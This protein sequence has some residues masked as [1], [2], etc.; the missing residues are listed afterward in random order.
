MVYGLG[1][2]AWISFG[3]THCYESI[4]Q[5]GAK[6]YPAE[7]QQTD[8]E[9]FTRRGFDVLTFRMASQQSITCSSVSSVSPGDVREPVCRPRHGGFARSYRFS[10][11]F[12]YPLR[13]T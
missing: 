9:N 13:C 5:G 10:H 4:V 11:S 7:Q 1:H 6:Q 2:E 3:N 12:W 8:V